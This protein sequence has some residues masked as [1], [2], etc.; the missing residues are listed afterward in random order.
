MSGSVWATNRR[1]PGLL[2]DG[3]EILDE[4]RRNA[5]LV[6]GVGDSEGNFG[7]LTAR[8]GVVL[9]DGDQF[10][11]GVDDQC[12]M[13]AG[14]LLGGPEQLCFGNGRSHAEEPEVGRGL[15]ELA[16][17]TPQGGD[18]VC[19]GGTDPYRAA[20][21]QQDVAGERRQQ[22]RPSRPACSLRAR[23]RLASHTSSPTSLA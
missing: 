9:A 18:V 5:L 8:L 6:M 16:I 19:L 23:R 10:T 2:G 11:V 4:H 17:E 3:G 15:A 21:R 12:H 13:V 22:P 7:I 20:G 14:V 1:K